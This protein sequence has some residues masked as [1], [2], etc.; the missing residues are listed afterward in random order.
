MIHFQ[1]EEYV[2]IFSYEFVEMYYEHWEDVGIKNLRMSPF[3]KMYESLG[4]NN[5]LRLYTAR[6]NNKLLVGYNLF[7]LSQHPHYV[8]TKLAEHDIIY[9]AP[10]YRK[11]LTGYKFLKYCIDDLKKEVQR[12][13]L[14]MKVDRQF[15][16]LGERLGFKLSEY[17]MV[18][19]T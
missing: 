5:H 16:K 4:K 15:I 11:G 3:Y 9:L 17:L 7:I 12:I 1:Q 19:E 2:K 18:L 6:T 10:E 8:D 14:R 13:N